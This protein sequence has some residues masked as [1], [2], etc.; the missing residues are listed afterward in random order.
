MFI[1]IVRSISNIW[2]VY[3]DKGEAER[4]AVL[5]NLNAEMG[6]SRQ[7]YYVAVEEVK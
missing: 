4:E 2:G 1:Y 6:G 3:K 5:A 7:F